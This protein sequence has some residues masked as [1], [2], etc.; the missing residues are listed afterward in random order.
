MIEDFIASARW[1][2]GRSDSTGKLRAVGFCFGGG[3]INTLAVRMGADLSAGVLSTARNRLPRMPR[4]SKPRG[5]CITPRWIR[6]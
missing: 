4:R 5:S 2:K 1:L 3:I 6:A